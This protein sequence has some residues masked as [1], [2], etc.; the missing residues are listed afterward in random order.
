M[1]FWKKGLV[2][3]TV[4]TS[5]VLLLISCLPAQNQSPTYDPAKNYA[6]FLVINS[7]VGK[8]VLENMKRHSLE[9][10]YEIGP[11]EYYNQGTKDFVPILKKLTASKQVKLVWIISGVWDIPDIKNAMA[12]VDFQGAYRY[13]PST[14]QG[15]AIIVQP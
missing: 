5:C 3:L 9:E 12:Q 8:N 1:N 7:T 2:V 6:A 15:G 14:E 13:A 11:I 10:N 4:I